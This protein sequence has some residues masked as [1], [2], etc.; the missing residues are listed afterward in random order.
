MSLLTTPAPGVRDHRRDAST[1]ARASRRALR[2]SVVAA[3]AAPIGLSML[4][5]IVRQVAFLGLPWCLQRAVDD[6][7]VPGDRGALLTWALVV[8][9]L[10]LVQFV[11]ICGWTYFSN[12]AD[13]RTAASL[14]GALVARLLRPEGVPP[15]PPSGVG[16]GADRELPSGAGDLVLR[17]GRDVDLVR[18]WVHGLP[19]WAVI[20]T[21]VLV[22]VPGLWSLDP[23]LLAVAVACVPL[24]VAVALLFPRVLT[25]RTVA[26]ARAH[27][28][29]ADEVDAVVRGAASLRGIGATAAMRRRHAAASSELTQRTVRVTDAQA[30]WEALGNGIPTLAIAIGVLVGAL[31]VLDGRLTAGGL[32]AFSTWMG[33]VGV[34]VQIGLTRIAQT[35]DA[36][37]GLDRLV[38]V[39]GDRGLGCQHLGD[40]GLG[41]QGHGRPGLEPRAGD[42]ASDDSRCAHADASGR[43][44]DPRL[45]AHREPLAPAGSG[46]AV[47]LAV[48]KAQVRA[49]TAPV[50]FVAGPGVLLALTGEVGIGKSTLLRALAGLAPLVAGTSETGASETGASETGTSEVT[51]PRDR[52]LRD[53]GL[54]DPS[55]IDPSLC[56]PELRIHLVPQ[57]PLVLAASVRDNLALGADV[58]DG[59]LRAALHDVGLDSELPDLDAVLADGDLSGGQVQRL[60]LARALVDDAPVLLLDDVTSA[61]D[62]PTQERI[63]A[64][65]RRESATRTVVVVTHRAGLLDA[66]DRVVTLRFA[67]Q[68]A[69]ADDAGEAR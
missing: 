1:H 49:G 25:P 36:R 42:S 23:L 60:A 27:A 4:G 6:G 20:G 34:A 65:L 28:A 67:R 7:L 69:P 32:L 50:S 59:A 54:R 55:P 31:A 29:R 68:Q 9:G 39:L 14:R 15:G 56:D 46:A 64:T 5:G 62:E 18:V 38:E 48:T 41:D 45:R 63:A 43:A 13:A 44:G 40:P 47:T 52:S 17:A 33:T 61:V 8:A 57:R 53:P 58:P 24:L 16:A 10:G 37:I 26:L 19:T 11:G 35:V 3:Q 51:T 21:T 2:R 30:R 22:L 66:A 12:L